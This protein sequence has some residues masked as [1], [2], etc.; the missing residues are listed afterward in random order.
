MANK[1]Q[2]KKYSFCPNTNKQSLCKKIT[3]HHT[4][5]TQ[6]LNRGIVAIS[7]FILRFLASSCS[8]NQTWSRVL[9]RPIRCH[10]VP[11]CFQVS[12]PHVDS[13][14]CGLAVCGRNTSEIYVAHPGEKA[15]W[16]CSSMPPLPV[17][18]NLD[19]NISPWSKWVS[20]QCYVVLFPAVAERRETKLE[21]RPELRL[22]VKLL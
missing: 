7:I 6:T 18:G 12:R 8:A 15:G 1:A 4:I 5:M 9:S 16:C 13:T 21:G 11:P 20:T 14:E 19:L 2:E 3:L 10:P 22:A 17:A